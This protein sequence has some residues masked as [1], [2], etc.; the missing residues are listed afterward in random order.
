MEG[1][2]AN[3]C[4]MRSP[5]THTPVQLQ[6]GCGNIGISSFNTNVFNM[7]IKTILGNGSKYY[8]L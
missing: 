1:L 5:Y 4:D 3:A 2:F 6:S 7:Q 8:K